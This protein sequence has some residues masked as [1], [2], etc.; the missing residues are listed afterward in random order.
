M[1]ETAKKPD[2]GG[3][4]LTLVSSVTDTL[5]VNLHLIRAHIKKHSATGHSFHECISN[6]IHYIM[7]I[8]VFCVPTLGQNG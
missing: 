8:V 6:K 5:L 7:E 2:Q 3:V 4:T 1:E